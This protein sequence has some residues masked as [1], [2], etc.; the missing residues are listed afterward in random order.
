M[1][2]IKYYLESLYYLTISK[3]KI[4][5]LPFAWYKHQYGCFQCET[6]RSDMLEHR[7]TIYLIRNSVKLIARLLPWRSQCLDQ[8]MAV[9]RMLSRR[10]LESTLYFGM[11][12]NPVGKWN[13][14]AWV[15]TGN[16]WAIGYQAKVTYTIVGTYA[17]FAGDIANRGSFRIFT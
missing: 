5:F 6:L 12:K 1:L 9:Q 4:V 14:H 16:C 10:D 17:Q 8:A 2:I 11:L 7:D 13:V 15:R 3:F